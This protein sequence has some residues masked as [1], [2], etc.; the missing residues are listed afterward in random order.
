MASRWNSHTAAPKNSKWLFDNL[1]VMDRL[2]KGMLKLIDEDGDSFAKKAEMYYHRRPEL[3]SH[4]NEFYRRYRA[5]AQRYDHATADLAK[6]IPPDQIQ[7][8]SS[9]NWSEPGVEGVVFVS[10]PSSPERTSEYK[11]NRRRPYWRAAGFDFFLGSGRS[12][13][14]ARKGSD[15][16]S[17]ESGSEFEYCKMMDGYENS[18]RL[19]ARIV[20]LENELRE[21]KER[22]QEHKNCENFIP[23]GEIFEL[24]SASSSSEIRSLR[25]AMEADAKQFEIE[26]SQRDHIVHE[27]K[28]WIGAMLNKSIGDNN[29]CDEA[30]VNTVDKPSLEIK[31][32]EQE[33]VIMELKS[34]AV[35]S[36]NKLLREKS[37]L[38][39]KLSGLMASAS[40]Y[41][42]KLQ[43]LEKRVKQLEAEK[44]KMRDD[45]EKR[46]AEL[47]RSLEESNL[48][49]VE[50]SSDKD[51]LEA[52]IKAQ[53]EGWRKLDEL[54]RELNL[55]H[56]RLIEDAEG[57]QKSS[58]EL[59]SRVEELE[60]E[61]VR[62]RA[63]M[64]DC[65]EEKREAIRQLCFSIEHYR[66]SYQRLWKKLQVQNRRPVITTAN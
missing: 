46:I 36:S 62:Q 3:I 7:S 9:D 56:E 14:L 27:Y 6:S 54:A 48:R 47:S 38:E 57:A 41:A 32:L 61:V 63:A 5:L 34:M 45:N 12:L 16:S 50:L 23:N 52:H 42:A 44:S 30:E 65:A 59:A 13:D 19:E 24:S 29:S 17:S 55:E 39:A 8:Q 37:T 20:G 66:V 35:H 15:E 25:E 64:E 21:T 26:I 11:V 18:S 40:S 2:F 49:F 60:E 1:E 28:S 10:S 43:T 31:I 53:G 33:Q 51:E 58:A 4:V 22:L